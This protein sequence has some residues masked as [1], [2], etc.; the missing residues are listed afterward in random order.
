MVDVMD[1][2]WELLDETLSGYT[3]N[4]SFITWS[5]VIVKI[6]QKSLFVVLITQH[7][8]VVAVIANILVA[9]KQTQSLSIQ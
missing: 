2:H 8:V 5:K 7:P 4:I 1:Y 3:Q 9:S 6:S